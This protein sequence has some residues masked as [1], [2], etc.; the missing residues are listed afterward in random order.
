MTRKLSSL[1]VIAKIHTSRPASRR[2][3]MPRRLVLGT[4]SLPRV[5]PTLPFLDSQEIYESEMVAKRIIMSKSAVESQSVSAMWIFFLAAL[6]LFRFIS[7]RIETKPENP[8][9][10]PFRAISGSLA[11]NIYRALVGRSLISVLLEIWDQP[12]CLINNL[13]PISF[14][15]WTCAVF[16]Y[17]PFF[18]FSLSIS[19]NAS[20]T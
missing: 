16:L 14:V 18:S 19:L 4:A 8:S 13:I 9:F 3:L 6:C 10:M 7:L 11:S 2:L 12:S 20:L 5:S 1:I 17:C 15:G